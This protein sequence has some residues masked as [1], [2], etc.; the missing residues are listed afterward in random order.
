MGAKSR[1]PVGSN[2]N[3]KV[4]LVATTVERMVPFALL[5]SLFTLGILLVFDSGQ[6]YGSLLVLGTAVVSLI[7][8]LYRA[9]Q[10]V[11]SR[12]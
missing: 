5:F 10:D 6:E 11:K 4:D 12:R 3:F 2:Y 9:W 8:G 7:A 1:G